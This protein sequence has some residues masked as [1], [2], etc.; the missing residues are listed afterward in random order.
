MG[1]PDLWRARR[2]ADGGAVPLSTLTALLAVRD[3]QVT[4]ANP[5]ALTELQAT[6]ADVVGAEL[7]ELA[8][9]GDRGRV[10]GLLADPDPA[11]PVVAALEIGGTRRHVELRADRDGDRVLV[12][13]RDRT[14]EHLLN[15]IVD[16]V[17][18]STLLLDESGL[19]R[20]Q[21]RS[22]SEQMPGGPD[23]GIGI[24]P[25]ER[26]HPEDL[27][28]VLDASARGI[29]NPGSRVR[30]VARSRAVDSDDAWQLIEMVGINAID[31]PDLAS[32]VVQVRDL[33]EAEEVES[34][35][36]TE[37]QFLSLAEAAPMG[38]I[39]S[40]LV[41]RTIYRNAAAK[42]LLG[43][44]EL[45]PDRDWR[46]LAGPASS[47]ALEALYASVVET[48]EP[49]SITAAF[50]IGE[51]SR[52]LRVH[53]APR[54]T[55][56]EN[57]YLIATIEDVTTE[58]EAR[59]ETDRLT[60]MLDATTDFVAVFRPG[61]EILYVNAAT[62]VLLDTLR[63]EGAAGALRDLIDDEP[64]RVWIEAA[65]EALATSDVWQGNLELNAGGGR[66]IPISAM[67]VIRRLPEGGLDWIAMHGRDISDL[68]EAENLLRELA[69]HDHLTGLANR[70][71]FNER[72]DRAVARHHRDG[73]GVAVMF[74]DLDGFKAINDEHG[75]AA[76]DLVLSVIADRLRLVTRETDTTARVGGDEFV[77]V[78]E[79]V[80]DD[81]EL[82]HLAERVIDAVT[83]PIT[84]PE[85]GRTAQPPVRIR[86]GISIGVG[87]AGPSRTDVDPDR[88]LT[89][90]DTAMYQAKAGG[91]AGWVL[92]HLD[93]SD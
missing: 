22:V 31:D 37:G 21:S 18:D 65:M 41:G 33:A 27:P 10:A 44:P 75:H 50:E 11:V 35:A 16:A 53:V 23:A 5:L 67:G 51:R 15:A 7:V 78:C 48:Q 58:I 30:H 91:G 89:L 86:V 73:D 6:S 71:L 90:A 79:G 36:H 61:G 24:N 2:D 17:A 39:V 42:D 87:V 43:Q 52:W 26:I 55:D 63:A 68:K 8:S 9:D 40:D 1:R 82:A 4:D 81:A 12:A 56:V 32:F 88:L 74:C 57:L 60:H 80:T 69:S 13:V 83:G 3:G 29:A 92:A 47:E 54:L 25:L 64:R 19:V 49:G 66:V 77:I 20:W 38:I 93:G 85:V 84:L 59:E 45:R 28:G 70:A 46:E 14:E 72:L 34:L 62:R 76:G